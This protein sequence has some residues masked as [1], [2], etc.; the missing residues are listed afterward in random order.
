MMNDEMFVEAAQ[1]L[2]TRVMNAGPAKTPQRLQQL[3]QLVLNRPPRAEE[4]SRLETYHAAQKSRVMAGGQ[5]ALLALGAFQKS[6]PPAEAVE[7]AT[8]VASA[9]V[10]M[11]LDEFINRE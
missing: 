4:L 5:E 7:A 3:F 1:S 9:R 6:I 10:L 8:L 2:A 11:N